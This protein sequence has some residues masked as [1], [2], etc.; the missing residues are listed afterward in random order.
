MDYDLEDFS[1]LFFFFVVVSFSRGGLYLNSQNIIIF[2]EMHPVQSVFFCFILCLSHIPQHTHPSHNPLPIWG[3]LAG[4]STHLL[5]WWAKLT[6][7]AINLIFRNKICACKMFIK[8]KIFLMWNLL[9]LFVGLFQA[10]GHSFPSPHIS[11]SVQAQAEPGSCLLIY[12]RYANTAH[13]C[14]SNVRRLLLPLWCCQS[15]DQFRKPPADPELMISFWSVSG[16][17]QME[18]PSIRKK[19]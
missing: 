8:C 5:C 19:K 14:T 18:A 4:T 17:I 6:A 16:R 10:C 3:A 15:W 9:G 7:E 2:L 11:Q 13:I 12:M 1:C